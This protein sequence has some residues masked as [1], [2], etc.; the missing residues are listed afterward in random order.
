MSGTPQKAV[1]PDL[2][3]KAGEAASRELDETSAN[4]SR[5]ADP[6]GPVNLP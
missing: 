4:Q 5:A 6:P 1:R 3:S 2:A